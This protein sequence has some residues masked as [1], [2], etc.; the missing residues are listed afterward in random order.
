LII[1]KGVAL[2]YHPFFI[3]RIKNKLMQSYIRSLDGLRTLAVAL[4][5]LYH[6]HLYKFG[7]AG[8]QVGWIGVQLFFVLSGFLITRILLAEKKHPPRY[9]FMRFYW[10]RTLRIFPLYF[11]YLLAVTALYVVS[12][13]PEGFPSQIAYLFTYTYNF[14]RLFGVWEHSPLFTHLWSL[15]VEEQFYIFWPF[16][17]Y[18][19]SEK[20]LSRAIVLIILGGP[21]L[22]FCLP[23]ILPDN[24]DVGGIIYWFTLSHVDAFATGGAISIFALDRKIKNPGTW[25]VVML[26]LVVLAGIV[27]MLSLDGTLVE[28]L[29]LDW[30]S[31]GYPIEVT[32]H[33]QHVW[34]Y[35]LL[36]L[37]FALCILWLIS[38]SGAGF[39]SWKF[40]VAAGKVSYGMYVFHW[41]FL[42][43][44]ERL[45]AWYGQLPV[46]AS[47]LVFV[48]Y[49]MVVFG[50]SWLSFYTYENWFIKH[51]DKFFK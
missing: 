49:F 33:Q 47:M 2:N 40:P 21:L 27:N 44:A 16:L 34:S 18:F 11:T 5:M 10:R 25:S 1:L 12:R 3:F 14:T 17:I 48:I 46:W 29:H 13:Q 22:R 30:T 45:L 8:L 4:V 9:Y 32:A 31:L 15:A 19:L 24:A 43:I 42:G 7:T 26:I 28:S 23:F 51:K 38:T 50:V 35:T 39:L 37:C 20:W 6:F 41:A 36:N